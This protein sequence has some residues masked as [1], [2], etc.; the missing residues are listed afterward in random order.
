[1]IVYD[2]WMDVWDECDKIGLLAVMLQGP[3]LFLQQFDSLLFLTDIDMSWGCLGIIEVMLGYIMR[4]LASIC[5]DLAKKYGKNQEITA[6]GIS[7]KK[8]HRP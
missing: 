4:H 1:M 8:Q 7:L 2:V 5:V 6:L 3:G